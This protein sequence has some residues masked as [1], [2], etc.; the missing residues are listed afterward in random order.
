[1]VVPA[2]TTTDEAAEPPSETVA[3]V[4]K[5]V[6]VIVTGVDPSVE[7]LFGLMLVTVGGAAPLEYVYAPAAVNAWLSGF[8]TS[9]STSAPAWA[10]VVAVIVV[11]LATFTPVAA[12]PPTFT[13][14]PATK[15]VPV[16]VTGVPPRA[17]PARCRGKTR[18]R[19]ARRRS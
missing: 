15:F 17:G 13:V 4:A 9:T 2:A 1:M 10:P 5:P 3:P 18:C 8:V 16:M 12:T 19:T 7:P 6:P 14:A 11:E